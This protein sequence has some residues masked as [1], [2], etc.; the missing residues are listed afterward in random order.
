MNE[1]TGRKETS[2]AII[3]FSL[4]PAVLYLTAN[5]CSALNAGAWIN[6]IINSGYVFAL[7]FAIRRYFNC[8]DENIIDVAAK[9]LGKK[10][11]LFI[12]YI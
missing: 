1:K 8:Y 4:S 11:A 9:V 7:I 2:A 6:F 5:R 10:S 12:G 3:L